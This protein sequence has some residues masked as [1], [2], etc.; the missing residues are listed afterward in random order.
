MPAATIIHAANG[1][2]RPADFPS[3]LNMFGLDVGSSNVEIWDPHWEV[4]VDIWGL[5]SRIPVA[6]VNTLLMRLPDVTRC[7]CADNQMFVPCLTIGCSPGA[8]GCL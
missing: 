1:Y 2:V 6:N 4:W 3:M 8:R 5:H 7:D